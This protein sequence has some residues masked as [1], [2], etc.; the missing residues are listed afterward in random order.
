FTNFKERWGFQRG[1]K[2]YRGG[3]ASPLWVARLSD[4]SVEK[5][6]RKDSNDSTP[7][8]FDNRIYFLSDRNGPVNLFCYDTD[9]KQ[10]TAPIPSNGF[11]IKSASMGPDAIA[12]EQ[13]GAI[14]V[15]DPATGKQQAVD[16]HVTGDFP[17]VRPHFAKAA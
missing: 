3:T 8:C 2:H 11:D 12:Y 6:P 9:T 16:I 1:L 15:F 7:M 14:H 5:L 10:V 4:S 17:A 13:F